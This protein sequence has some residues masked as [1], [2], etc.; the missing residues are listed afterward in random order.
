VKGTSIAHATEDT[1]Q[2]HIETRF[3]L[4]LDA[5]IHLGDESWYPLRR[6]LLSNRCTRTGGTGGG[7]G[8]GNQCSGQAGSLPWS[9]LSFDGRRIRGSNDAGATA[10]V[11]FDANT[12]IWPASPGMFGAFSNVAGATDVAGDSVTQWT[13]EPSYN[14]S[15]CANVAPYGK[16]CGE[17]AGPGSKI[18]ELYDPA[19]GCVE[20]DYAF[21]DWSSAGSTNSSSQISLID[22]SVDGSR[23]FP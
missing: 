22:S 16:L 20:S 13:V 2:D 19:I 9:H 12:G 5:P 1:H 11:L 23:G 4:V 6:E 21:T 15:N 17:P 3:V 14:S 18:Y 8:S 10:Q 7:N